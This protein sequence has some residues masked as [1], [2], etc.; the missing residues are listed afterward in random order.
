ML[1]GSGATHSFISTMFADCWDRSKDNIRQTSRTVLSS[2]DIMLSNYWLHDV[3]VV[4]SRRELSVDLVVLDIVDY[5]V[6]LG[7]DFLSKYGATI[8]CKAKVVSLQLPGEERFMFVGDRCSSQKMF[9]SAM[10]VRK[11]LANRCTSYLANRCTSYL[12]TIVDPTKKE[13]D[14][15]SEVPAVNEFTSVFPE[16]FPG[17]P[18]DREVTFEIEVLLGTFP[19]SKTPYRMVPVEWKEL[20][21][22]IQ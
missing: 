6:I 15:L 7:M 11:W 20:Q 4:I 12:A 17:L 16:E 9:V 19:I 21:T 22:Q 13:K 18:P 10:K 3:P 8:D 2:N 14:E 5:D 1:F